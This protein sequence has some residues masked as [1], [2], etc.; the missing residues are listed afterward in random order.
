MFGR[1]LA[2]PIQGFYPHFDPSFCHV[3]PGGGK[4]ALDNGMVENTV[5][6]LATARLT[7]SGRRLRIATIIVFST[8]FSV[9][10]LGVK[11]SQQ[12]IFN[13][14][15]QGFNPV[16]KVPKAIQMGTCGREIVV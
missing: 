11:R 8:S 5:V 13:L 6:D 4:L 1:C 12:L 7:R 9:R 14:S 3:V 16:G 2:Y 15:L 10:Q